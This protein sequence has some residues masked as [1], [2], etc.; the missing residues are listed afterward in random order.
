[1]WGERTFDVTTRLA[2]PNIEAG[3]CAN[4][5]LRSSVSGEDNGGTRM[6]A[7]RILALALLLALIA[8]PALAEDDDDADTD[9]EEV[10]EVDFAR[11]GL[12]L[13]ARG[14]YAL[15]D[16]SDDESHRAENTDGVGITLGY[17]MSPF[18]ALEADFEWTRDYIH[19]DERDVMLF[20]TSVR[21]K[22]YPLQGRFQPFAMGGI[23]IVAT[24]VSNRGGQ[25]PK[26]DQADWAF[27]AGGGMD[28]HINNNWFVT[29]E[30][31]YVAMVGN[32]QHLNYAAFGLGITYRFNTPDDDY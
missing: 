1:M 26:G 20:N 4:H 12:Y 3:S 29:A 9:T 30:A 31:S 14:I 25:K 13:G 28:M 15:E 23:G 2:I 6:R 21:G 18:V 11:E 8:A 19:P 16:W 17:R 10:E 24:S 32:V 5:L 22:V 27:R 7:A